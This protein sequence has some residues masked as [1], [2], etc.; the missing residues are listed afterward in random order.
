M[1]IWK[2]AMAIGNFTRIFFAVLFQYIPTKL[3]QFHGN[4]N[5]FLKYPENSVI[6]ATPQKLMNIDGIYE[7]KNIR[8]H[9]RFSQVRRF[10]V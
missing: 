7:D 9:V 3:N 4:L 6:I 8:K 5:T 10:R 1:K 2:I